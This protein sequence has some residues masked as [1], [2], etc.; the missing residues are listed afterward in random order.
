MR[1][2]FEALLL[3]KT[4][5]QTKLCMIHQIYAIAL[6]SCLQFFSLELIYNFLFVITGPKSDSINCIPQ[7]CSHY[8]Y[9]KNIW[10]NNQSKES[11]TIVKC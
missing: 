9:M 8:Y 6:Y 1:M 2:P 10:L 4:N 3:Q 7:A 11:P 5:V